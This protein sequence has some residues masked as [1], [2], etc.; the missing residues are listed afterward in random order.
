MKT[1]TE[2]KKSLETLEKNLQKKQN[3][4]HT[5]LDEQQKT[6]TL[7]KTKEQKDKLARLEQQ[8]KAQEQLQKSLRTEKESCGVH[9][10]EMAHL[11][12]KYDLFGKNHQQHAQRYKKFIDDFSKKLSKSPL[13][14]RVDCSNK[15][16]AMFS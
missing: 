7:V 6:V 8:V 14:A 11:Q 5:A 2:R 10:E 13:Q 9:V 4:G 16:I 3:I 1:Q 12:K 15:L